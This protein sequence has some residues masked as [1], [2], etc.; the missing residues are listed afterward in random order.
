[1]EFLES[2]LQKIFQAYLRGVSCVLLGIC[3]V[4]REKYIPKRSRTRSSHMR[5]ILKRKLEFLRPF[6]VSCTVVDGSF[7]EKREIK[8]NRAVFTSRQT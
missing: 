3:S 5:N 4:S 1:M 7:R 2:A 8:N 6:Y